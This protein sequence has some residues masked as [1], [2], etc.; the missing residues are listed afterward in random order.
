M[1]LK[2][3]TQTQQQRPESPAVALT[4]HVCESIQKYAKKRKG[5]FAL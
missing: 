4:W 2:Y 1:A 3:V 5:E